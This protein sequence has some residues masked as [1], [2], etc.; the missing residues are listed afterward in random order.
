MWRYWYSKKQDAAIQ[1]LREHDDDFIGCLCVILGGKPIRYTEVTQTDRP[2]GLWDD[3]EL[4]GTADIFVAPDS[5]NRLKRY[6]QGSMS[7]ALSF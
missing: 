7:L 2:A 6:T 5:L 3:Y 1:E 4:V